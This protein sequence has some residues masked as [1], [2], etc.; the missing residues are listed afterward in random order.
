MK[1]TAT[2]GAGAAGAAD[3]VGV[4]GRGAGQLVVHDRVQRIHMQAARSHVGGHQHL[5][6]AG[7]ERSQH[8]T[9][10]PL[11]QLAMQHAGLEAVRMQLLRDEVRRVAAGHEDQH[12]LPGRIAQQLSQ[13]GQALGTV[14]LDGALRD[15]RRRLGDLDAHGVTQ[16]L[17][18]Q[19]LDRRREGGGEQQAWRR[20][21]SSASRRCNSSA[22]PCPSRRSASSS[23]RCCTPASVRPL[24]ASRSSSRPGVATITSRRRAGHQLRV[25]GHAAEGQRD[26]RPVQ[27]QGGQLAQQFSG[28]GR[29]LAGRRQHQ[30]AAA[31][32]V[33]NRPGAAAAAARRRRSCPSRSVRGPAHRA[34]NN[35]RQG[36]R[37][38]GGVGA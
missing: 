27:Q 18:G 5:H 23:T 8:I 1:L 34:R 28:L 29:Q 14:Q 38:H 9:A 31:P 20:A 22:K 36:R 3:A 21:G 35:G 11:A 2:L 12:A 7:L 17:R 6:A 19:G 13:R 16:Q 25:D 26:A 15:L 4:V 32:A 33:A 30:H 10:R 37:L 24:C